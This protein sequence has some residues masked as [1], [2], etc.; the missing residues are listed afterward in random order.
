M[1]NVTRPA[2]GPAC[3]SSGTVYNQADVVNAL[4]SV[5]YG[6]CYICERGEIQDVEIEH[7]LPLAYGGGRMDWNNLFYSCRRCNG[8]KSNGHLNLLNCTDSATRVCMEIRLR[9]YPTP[10][11]RILV[12]ASSTAPSIETQNTVNLL[13]ACYNNSTTAQRGISREALTEQIFDFMCT[14]IE[15][16]RL[17]KNPST[18][19]SNRK[20]A[21]ET[22]EAMLD[23]SHPF[24]AFWRW[25]YLDDSYL[26][27]NHP[28]LGRSF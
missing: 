17:I 8:I 15:A 1:F 9:A 27:T 6:K 20:D 16:R 19:R 23:D 3:L 4:K 24:S 13:D 12:E 21:L 5:F 28:A 14:F 26:T 10:D 2:S 7:F 22:I 11:S 18:G 25:Q